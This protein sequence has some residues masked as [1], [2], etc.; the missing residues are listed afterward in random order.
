MKWRIIDLTQD[1]FN[2]IPVYPAI[3]VPSSTPPKRTRKPP[4]PTGTRPRGTHLH[5]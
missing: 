2:G 4:T 1:I 5:V 3:S